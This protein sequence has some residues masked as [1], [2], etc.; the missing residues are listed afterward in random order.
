[1][2]NNLWKI[3]LFKLKKYISKYEFNIWILPLQVLINNNI[4]NLYAPNKFIIN[5]VKDKYLYYINNFFLKY[6]ENKNIK[7][8]F[9]FLIGSKNNIINN[10]L[11]SN[12]YYF[13]NNKY[14]NNLYNFKEF[15]HC[16]LFK[17]YNF[18]NFICN[19]CNILAYKSSIK[20]CNFFNNFKYLLIYSNTGL[21]K[22]HLLNS[23]GNR[24]NYLYNYKRN[25]LY[26]NMK[27][28]LNKIKYFLYND[29][30]KDF[31]F[32]LK[33]ISIFLIDDIQFLYNYKYIQNE[34]LNILNFLLNYNK[35]IVL[36]S[37]FNINKLNGINNKIISKLYY[38]FFSIKINN[39]NSNLRYKF[40]VNK[41][42]NISFNLDKKI[43]FF[44]SKYLN[45]NFNKLENILY[46]IYINS[47]NLNY[48]YKIN[49]NFIK[50]MLYEF[51][52]INNSNINIK[53]YNIQKIICKYYNITI[54]NLLSKYRY[55][56]FVWARQVSIAISKK[57]TNYSLIKLG[58]YFG[59][60]SNSYILYSY[61]K[62]KRLYVNNYKVKLEINKLI[63][64]IIYNK[65]EIYNKK[66]KIN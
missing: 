46:I 29:L 30:I 15:N 31:I 17:K 14:K 58:L 47:I 50:N 35:F 63:K 39:S 25:V 3:C 28:L 45:L 62:I 54:N 53:I 22:T 61:N 12:Y 27:I 59:G 49:I 20:I 23:I 36:T 51:I 2:S 37:R 40:L 55:K 21:G 32:Y 1:M 24:I 44:I 9:N 60:L 4:I 8:V 5:Y 13:N 33:S 64:L 65:N 34:F 10:F 57:L 11:K 18:N 19:N 52:Y 48:L 43:L 41:C 7:P 56:S 66:K 42:K 16:N 38:N 26:I 6:W